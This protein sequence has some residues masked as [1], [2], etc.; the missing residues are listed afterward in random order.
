MSTVSPSSGSSTVGTA[1]SGARSTEDRVRWSPGL[2]CTPGGEDERIPVVEVGIGVG[3]FCRVGS[4]RDG[5]VRTLLYVRP[6]RLGEEDEGSKAGS[7]VGGGRFVPA[8]FG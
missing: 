2:A 3:Y 7:K 6:G 5:D 8:I 4:I 1:E